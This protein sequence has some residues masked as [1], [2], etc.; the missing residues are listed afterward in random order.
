MQRLFD[1]SSRGEPRIFRQY[2]PSD[3]P[4]VLV[5]VGAGDGTTS[6]LS[7]EFVEEGWRALLIEEDIDLFRQ[8]RSC[9][10]SNANAVCVQASLSAVTAASQ[11][12]Y[13]TIGAFVGAVRDAFATTAASPQPLTTVLAEN[14]FAG[15]IGI[16]IVS[17]AENAI[18]VLQGASLGH[19][20]PRLIVTRDDRA[21]WEGHEHKYR[22]LAGAGY[23]FAAVAG[24]YSIWSFGATAPAHSPSER[25]SLPVLPERTSG[26]AAF[27]HPLDHGASG[28][29]F[30]ASQVLTAGWAF[31]E[32]T[33]TVPPFVYLKLEDRLAGTTEYIQGWRCSRPDVAATFQQPQLVKA[34]FRALAPLGRCQAGAYSIE[35]LQADEAAI[36][37]SEA[38]F[39]PSLASEEFEKTTR[40]GL[41]RKFLYGSGLEIGA[42]QRALAIPGT[43]AVRYVDRFGLGDLLSHYPE[44][45]GMPLQPP[46]LID[47]GETLATIADNSQD[48]LIAN[49]F[50]EHC[51]N[52]LRALQNLLRKL[53]PG[54]ILYMAVPDKRYTFD[55]ERPITRYETLCSTYQSGARADREAL[56][57]EWVHYLER[58]EGADAAARA[59]ELL[60]ADYSIH[61]NVWTVDELVEQ[62]CRARRDFALPFQIA[63][64]ACCA[65]EAILVLR[66]SFIPTR[67][68]SHQVP[69]KPADPAI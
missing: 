11:K 66:R 4:R 7:R 52:P 37:R 9:C 16:L 38:E 2:L 1:Y 69:L 45:D 28:G 20:R 35:V 32:A 49:H 23:K 48:F 50:L 51:R 60:A 57:C 12:Q 58:R 5:E 46:D 15:D 56:F 34:G 3:A 26:R 62:L 22:L 64:I 41:A 44:L 33:F 36:Y 42:L 47:D 8:L 27:D 18:D 43:A 67:Y 24:D 54:G 19:L 30:G 53:K 39:S 21:C 6:S 55:S 59:A 68:A 14:Q 13:R 25:A 63:S 29:M 40:E 17:R 10:K 61:Y 65:N 31:D